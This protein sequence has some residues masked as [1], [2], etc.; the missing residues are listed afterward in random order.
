ML[1]ET[2]SFEAMLDDL[3]I[4]SGGLVYLAQLVQPHSPLPELERDRSCSTPCGAGLLPRGT[5]AMPSYAYGKSFEG[6]RLWSVYRRYLSERPVFDVRATPAA[7]GYLPELLRRSPAAH[8]SLHFLCSTCAEGRLAREITQGQELVPNAWAPGSSFVTMSQMDVT[9]VGLGVTL[10]TTS[11]SPVVDYLLGDRHPTPIF[12]P[13][14]KRGTIVDWDGRTR[15]M[16]V[17]DPYPAAGR[18]M[19]PSRVFEES[20]TLRNALRQRDHDGMRHFAYRFAPFLKAASAQARDAYRGQGR[21][22]SVARALR[23]ALA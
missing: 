18:W 22:L 9:L 20:P 16:E 6:E 11:F 3:E 2:I 23:P 19:K 21:D 4:E 14:L 12:E 17:C 8:R 13:E 7:I 10:D 5:L 15:E 1:S